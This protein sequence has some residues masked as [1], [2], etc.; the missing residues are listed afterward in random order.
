MGLELMEVVIERHRERLG[1]RK[2]KLITIDMDPTE[3]QTHGA[4]QLSMFNG[5]YDAYCYL[6]QL[7]FLSFDKEPEQYLFAAMLRPGLAPAHKGAIGILKRVLPRLRKSFPKARI[8]VRLD[9]GFATPKLFE[10]LEEEQRVRY[11]VGVT[12]NSVV[13]GRIEPMM[14]RVRKAS[15]KSAETENEFGETQYAAKSWKKKER[16]VIM[17]AEV[18]R[19]DGREP[20]DNARFVVTN[21]LHKPE[22]VYRIYRG[23]GDSENR[24]K[25]LKN[26]LEMDRTSCSSFWANQLRV[27]LTATAY[28]LFQEMQW[29]AARRSGQRLSVGTLRIRLIKI[30]ARIERSVRRTVVHLAENHPWRSEWIQLAR[31]CGASLG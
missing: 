17:K 31:L 8:L 19:L 30:G 22:N 24:I 5:H 23:R 21:L 20:K 10:F 25:E 28:V 13:K 9:G 12:S 4:Q 2:V 3:D 6:P 15:E 14:E 26:D 11:L 16:R 7:A 18:V 27:L 1:R 29:R